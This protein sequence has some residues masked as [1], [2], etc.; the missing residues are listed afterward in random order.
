MRSGIDGH[1]Y[2]ILGNLAQKS[3]KY[4]STAQYLDSEIGYSNFAVETAVSNEKVQYP[5]W[6]NM[7]SWKNLSPRY[8]SRELLEKRTRFWEVI[9]KVSGRGAFQRKIASNNNGIFQHFDNMA[10]WC[11]I[12]QD[13]FNIPS[14]LILAG[15]QIVWCHCIASDNFLTQSQL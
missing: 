6:N 4:I 9:L 13:S 12:D 2:R 3:G 1:P 10:M 7:V 14:W 8:D 15:V 5:K 11:P